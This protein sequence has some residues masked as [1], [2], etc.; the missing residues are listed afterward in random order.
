M[1]AGLAVGVSVSVGRGSPAE[2][3]APP[4]PGPERTAPQ[5]EAGSRGLRG[6]S[7]TGL[8]GEG[9]VQLNLGWWAGGVCPLPTP[10]S[11][12]RGQQG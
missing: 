5:A 11:A 10:Y 7:P 4:L 2:A 1:A 9:V 12:G 6:T 3:Q 8:D